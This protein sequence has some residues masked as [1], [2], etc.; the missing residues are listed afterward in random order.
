LQSLADGYITEATVSIFDGESTHVLD[1]ICSGDLT[2]EQLEIAAEATGIDIDLLR[3]VNICAWT[4][5]DASLV[6]EIGRS[7]RLD[8]QADGK[9][10]TSTTTI[11]PVVALDSLWFQLAERDANDD[12]LGFIWATLSDPAI[13]GNQYRWFAKRINDGEDGEPKDDSFIAPL[14][15]VFEDRYVNGLTFDFNYNR[16]EQ[17]YS[18]AEDDNNEEA[19]F[20][21][22]GDVVVVKFTSIDQGVFKFYDSYANNVAS[23]G[24]L[25]SNPA[26]VR[27]NVSG[28]LGVWAGYSA[29]LDTVICIP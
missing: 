25:F 8:V 17:A 5:L 26:N 2:D 19:G 24:D 7:Y 23:A 13:L 9:S 12:S 4:I 6:G 1:R 28:G 11:P 15:S 3:S 14:F 21:K 27:S 16:G 18:T 22:R 29:S 20:F 10:L